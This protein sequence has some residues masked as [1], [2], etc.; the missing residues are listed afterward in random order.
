M[1]QQIHVC[2]NGHKHV[3]ILCNKAVARD[4]YHCIH[5]INTV[6]YENRHIV[7]KH[8]AVILKCIHSGSTKE[9][10]FTKPRMLTLAPPRKAMK[11]QRIKFPRIMKESFC[12]ESKKSL[13]RQS[14][15]TE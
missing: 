8:N 11:S 7:T 12:G 2:G 6:F 5:K 3:C 15:L 4:V 13:D 9:I 1:G 10:Q 14:V